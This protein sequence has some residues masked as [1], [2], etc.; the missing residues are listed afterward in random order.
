MLDQ[1]LGRLR[2]E[3]IRKSKGELFDQLRICLLGENNALRHGQVAQELG[4]TAGS[5]KVASHRLRARFRELVR[6]EIAQ[7]VHNPEDI[8]D[9][10]RELFG[11]LAP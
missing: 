4:M 6:E 10:I 2:E 7:T 3:Y 1:V 9:E 11:A 5:V 8:E